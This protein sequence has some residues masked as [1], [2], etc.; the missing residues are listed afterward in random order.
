MKNLFKTKTFWAG[1]AT[2]ISG[3]GLIITG[4]KVNGILLISQGIGQICD[5]RYLKIIALAIIDTIAAL[6]FI[7]LIFSACYLLLKKNL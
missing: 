1:L 5:M 2:L 6:I 4:D 3:A 7:A